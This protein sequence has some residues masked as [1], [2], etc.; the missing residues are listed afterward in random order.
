MKAPP[1]GEAQ[2]LVL[3]TEVLSLFNLAGTED[4]L[5]RRDCFSLQEEPVSHFMWDP[6]KAPSLFVSSGPSRKRVWR[7]EECASFPSEVPSTEI[8]SL[9]LILLSLQGSGRFR[10]FLFKSL[11]Q[12]GLVSP[13]LLGNEE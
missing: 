3:E 12:F 8:L 13:D 7:A 9:H 4:T 6:R 10:A 2:T 5:G 11:I 1:T